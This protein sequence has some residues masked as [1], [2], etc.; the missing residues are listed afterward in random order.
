MKREISY[1]IPIKLE[2][3]RQ[4]FENLCSN[5]LENPEEMNTFLDAVDLPTLT[6]EDVNHLNRSITSHESEAVMVSQQRKAQA[7]TDSPLNSPR[8]LKKN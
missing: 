8:P 7:Q 5:E 4:Y 1:Q 3:Y 2:D 6:H